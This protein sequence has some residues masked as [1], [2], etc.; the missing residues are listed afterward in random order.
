MLKSS[1]SV[2]GGKVFIGSLDGYMYALDSNNG[3]IVWQTK[4]NGPIESSPTAAYNAVYFTSQE[5]TTG[6]LYK[7][8]ANTGDVIWKQQLPY[9]YQFTGGD[10]MLGSPSVAQ[11]MV[12]ATANIRTYYG[13]NDTT[14]AYC[15]DSNRSSRYRIRGSLTNLR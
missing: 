7:L 11:G 6:V 4:T 14:G 3:N 15:M 2:S 10:E 13:I 1:P 5:P 8:N 12:F 9:E